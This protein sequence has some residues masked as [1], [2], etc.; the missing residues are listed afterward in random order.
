MLQ[1][2]VAITGYSVFIFTSCVFICLV[3][4]MN[5]FVVL[6]RGKVGLNLYFSP[7]FADLIYLLRLD[8]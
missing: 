7:A 4:V 8:I 5:A 2:A 1:V 3:L 6:K